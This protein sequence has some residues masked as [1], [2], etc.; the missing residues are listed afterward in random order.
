[1]QRK[2]KP[3]VQFELTD[4]TREAVQVWI[5]QAKL[6]SDQ[7]LFP[8]RVHASPHLSTRQHAKI[9]DSWVSSNGL[10]PGE[11]NTTRVALTGLSAKCHLPNM[12]VDSKRMLFR[13]I[14]QLPT[15]SHR[16]WHKERG[17]LTTAALENYE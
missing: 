10:K 2:T 12:P 9:V 14:V 5:A 7:F 16:L 13:R 8:S 1:M 15:D 17:P 6:T 11:W 4:Q 3:P